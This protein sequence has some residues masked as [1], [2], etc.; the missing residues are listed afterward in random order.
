MVLFPQVCRSVFPVPAQFKYFKGAGFYAENIFASEEVGVETLYNFLGY[1]FIGGLLPAGSWDF[2]NDGQLDFVLEFDFNVPAADEGL[3]VT[4][5][6]LTD[7]V[8][9]DLTES[10]YD[11]VVYG[12]INGQPVP[13]IVGTFEQKG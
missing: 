5:N 11:A 2:D 8:A 1:T 9:A 6:D 10:S 7:I 4:S 3:I 12:I 13:I